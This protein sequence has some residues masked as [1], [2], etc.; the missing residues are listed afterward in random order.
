MPAAAHSAPDAKFLKS[1]WVTPLGTSS[2]KEGGK[3]PRTPDCRLLEL[4]LGLGLRRLQPVEL[5]FE[6]DLFDG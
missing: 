5:G 2:G 3:R 4:R 6:R 1:G